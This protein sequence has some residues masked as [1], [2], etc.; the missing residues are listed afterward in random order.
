[1]GDREKELLAEMW[2]IILD[3]LKRNIEKAKVD[4]EAIRKKQAFIIE[5]ITVDIM[6]G[7]RRPSASWVNE[8]IKHYIDLGTLI[9]R[10]DALTRLTEEA[11]KL[12]L[13][14]DPKKIEKVIENYRKHEKE[15]LASF[16]KKSMILQARFKP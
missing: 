12:Q 1:M 15:V 14:K 3:D 9:S 4:N 10:N 6:L 13:M 7:E 16:P 5:K 11:T 8:G 2:R